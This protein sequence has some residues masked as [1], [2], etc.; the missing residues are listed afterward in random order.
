MKNRN[1]II[2]ISILALIGLGSIYLK[3]KYVQPTD[4]IKY[5]DANQISFEDF[6]GK[7]DR[8]KSS[9]SNS[10]GEYRILEKLSCSNDQVNFTVYSY[11]IPQD[12]WLDDKTDSSSLVNQRLI[13]KC[14]ELYARKL[15]KKLLEL[16]EPCKTDLDEI[17]EQNY[18]DLQ[19]FMAEI[20]EDCRVDD[21]QLRKEKVNN[22]NLKLDSLL[23]GYSDFTN[24]KK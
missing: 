22:W 20:N 18:S 24:E 16:P 21:E 12:S 10:F 15:R 9:R 6:K 2:L 11:M 5:S 7:V 4:I 23:I 17:G 19:D 13:F 14:Y 3:P 8:D 1:L